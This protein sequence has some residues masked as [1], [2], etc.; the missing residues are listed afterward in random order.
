MALKKFNPVTPGRRNMTVEDFSDLD[1]VRPK[2]SLTRGKKRIDGRNNL[3]R[4]TMRRRG[5]GHKRLYREIDFKRDKDGI[6]GIVET[7]E[8]DP[9]RS[10]RI[11]LIK[12]A[13]G[14]RRYILAPKGLKQGDAVQ[15]GI[16]AP[17]KNGNCLPLA[18][19]PVGETVHAIELSAGRGAVL[20]RSAGTFVQIVARE[21]GFTTIQLPSGELRKVSDKCRAV[22]GSV[23]NEE[24]ENVVIGKAGRTR[25]MGRQ[26]KVRGVVQNPVDHP[27]GGGEGKSPQGNPHPVTPWGKPTKGY[28][29]RHKK[30]ASSQ[31]IVKR[32]K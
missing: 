22:V 12:Y 2:K 14:E 32:R 10:A 1:K 6:K 11:A 5:A 28:K 19:I 18:S 27:H 17:V 26:P 20:A 9:N 16:D 23:G 29:T 8:Y 21:S 24:H 31:Y 3:G 13:D 7:L 30:K 4:M 15:S 25:W